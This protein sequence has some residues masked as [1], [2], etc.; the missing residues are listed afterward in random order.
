[1]LLLVRENMDGF[2]SLY[3]GIRIVGCFFIFS[4]G[5]LKSF[6]HFLHYIELYV[7][8]WLD[9]LLVIFK[10]FVLCIFKDQVLLI[11]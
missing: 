3:G 2:L 11:P 8:S 1:M 4:L 9:H 5:L 7:G 6:Y 10:E